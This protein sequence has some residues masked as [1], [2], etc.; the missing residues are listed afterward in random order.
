M[1]GSHD[2]LFS[3]VMGYLSRDSYHWMTEPIWKR[4]SSQWFPA[5]S[6]VPLSWTSHFSWGISE[7][8]AM[9]AHLGLV[10][11]RLGV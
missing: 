7:E 8:E 1:L 10:R 9:H 5:P 4:I 3:T 6:H 11:L 2:G